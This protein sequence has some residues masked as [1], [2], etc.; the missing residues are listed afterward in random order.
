METTMM[1]MMMVIWYCYSY[2]QKAIFRV[3]R[4]RVISCGSLGGFHW[5]GDALDLFL[6]AFE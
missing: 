4:E 5:Q 6:V 1:M 2:E 3:F